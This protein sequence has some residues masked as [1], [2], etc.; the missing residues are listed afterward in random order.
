MMI[1]NNF[2]TDK[3]S[4]EAMT[5]GINAIKEVTGRCPLAMT[6]ELLQ[7]LARYK[8]HKDKNVM[9]SARALMQ[10]FRAVNP[11]ML[12]RKDRVSTLTEARSHY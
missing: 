6:E 9:M 12:H 5:V 3:N 7:D 1:A 2:V 8:T 4:G 10:L 11:Q